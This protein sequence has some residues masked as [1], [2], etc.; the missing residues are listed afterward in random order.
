MP[1]KPL[2]LATLAL[3]LAAAPASADPVAAPGATADVAG[4]AAT[5]Q[6]LNAYVAFMN[7]TLRAMDSLERYRSWVNMKTGPTGRE[8]LIYG[9]YEVYDTHDEKAAAEAALSAPPRLP[10]LDE[11]MRAYIA[12]NDALA[13]VLNKAA[14]YCEREDYKLDHMQRGKELHAQIVAL[15]GA[16]VAARARLEAVLGKA[17]L[18][19]DEIRLATMEKTEG[20]DARWHAG[21]VM[22]RAKQALDALQAAHGGG[23]DMPA[24]AAAM[25]D[26]GTAV[27]G[28]DDYRA[29][30]PRAFS[31]F[32]TFP[33]SLLGR[34]REVQGR[35]QRTHG[36][37]RRAAG[38]DMTFIMSDYDTMVTTAGLPGMFDRK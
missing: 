33:D 30:H 35:L 6:K 16:F 37:L 15:G 23:V 19:L 2:V 12:A 38:L 18:Q 27:S 36:N 25:T 8:R 29:E 4:L 20:R 22:M 14:G 34:L 3:L 26:L 31:A 10:D 24:F 11:A 13:P 32:S 17:K 21:T 7:R 1:V 9:A 5:T 28:L